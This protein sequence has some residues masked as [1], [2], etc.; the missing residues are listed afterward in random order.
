MS[1]ELDRI[2]TAQA[3]LA[4]LGVTL[5]DLHRAQRPPVPTMA[6]Y[7]SAHDLG[8]FRVERLPCHNHVVTAEEVQ[9]H[10]PDT[11]GHTAGHRL[12]RFT[13]AAYQQVA[14]VL[15]A[16]GLAALLGHF[17]DIGWRGILDELVGYWGG[18]IRPVTRSVL[19]V[20]VSTPLRWTFGWRV[21][22][23]L[24]ARDYL[25]VGAILAA[26]SIRIRVKAVIRLRGV[27]I[28]RDLFH[29]FFESVLPVFVVLALI[30]PVILLSLV[31]LA[32]FSRDADFARDARIAVLPIV[33][34]GLL[35]V[36]NYLVL[37]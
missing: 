6:E 8:C 26:S 36:M 35:L 28:G 20:L 32:I 29:E 24:I 9:P 17:V 7:L 21:E 37:T 23:P 19:D 14:A 2:A 1:A 33:Y 3:M 18:L 10:A 12:A 4:E 5:A 34:L 13:W 31:L 16:F 11:G 27:P 15:A 25:A 22:V 30:W